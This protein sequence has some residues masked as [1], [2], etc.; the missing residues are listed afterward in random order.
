MG[1][2]RKKSSVKDEP[3]CGGSKLPDV[4]LALSPRQR[5][6]V[7]LDDRPL[8][9]RAR[10]ATSEPTLQWGGGTLLGPSSRA[11]GHLVRLWTRPKPKLEFNP[12]WRTLLADWNELPGWQNSGRIQQHQVYQDIPLE[13]RKPHIK[14]RSGDQGIDSELCS[15]LPP[16]VLFLCAGLR[17]KIPFVGYMSFHITSDQSRHPGIRQSWSAPQPSA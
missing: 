14:H 10:V 6:P 2:E 7:Q 4:F 3:R 11:R 16:W 17:Q 12:G 5:R 13:L 1:R 9:G 8:S 15:I